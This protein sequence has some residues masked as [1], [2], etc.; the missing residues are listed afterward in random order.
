MRCGPQGGFGKPSGDDVGR[1]DVADFE[2]DCCQII[3]TYPGYRLEHIA[4]LTPYQFHMLLRGG[5]PEPKKSAKRVTG[6]GLDDLAKVFA[7]REKNVQHP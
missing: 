5:E 1:D 3:H 7:E 2:R 4:D 6:K